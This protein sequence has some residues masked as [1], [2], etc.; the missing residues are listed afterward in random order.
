MI[1]KTTKAEKPRKS[2]PNNWLTIQKEMVPKAAQT[3][4]SNVPEARRDL[5]ATIFSLSATDKA[6]TQISSFFP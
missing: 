1:T 5:V 6:G 3:A 2:Q 4:S